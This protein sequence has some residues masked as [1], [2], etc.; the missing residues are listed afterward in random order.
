M[1]EIKWWFQKI[2]R[3]YYSSKKYGWKFFFSRKYRRYIKN[4]NIK[5][6]YGSGFLARKKSV[7]RILTRRD[8]CFCR[9]CNRKFEE[10]SLTIDHIK[11]RANGGDNR[12]N[13]LQLLCRPCHN[14]KDN[15]KR[16]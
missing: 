8:G 3:R 14:I 4:R 11:P 16:K 2:I 9:M 12:Y 10:I 7:R 13:N 1:R 5:L 15:D 6:K